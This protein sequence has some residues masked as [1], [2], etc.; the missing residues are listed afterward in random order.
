TAIPWHETCSWS[1]E[2]LGHED[3]AQAFSE[4]GTHS[5][6]RHPEP[7]GGRGRRR[8]SVALLR[9]LRRR[10][11]QPPQQ[12]RRR[13][14]KVFRRYRVDWRWLERRMG[15]RWLGPRLGLVRLK[16]EPRR[17]LPSAP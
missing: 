17:P 7:A 1:V 4:K 9:P 16:R 15:W 5:C 10:D 12:L 3:I 11:G 8:V 6:A 13:L 14:E 2:E